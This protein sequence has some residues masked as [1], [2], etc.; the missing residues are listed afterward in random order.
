MDL[1]KIQSEELEIEL[2]PAIGGRINQI[3]S[4]QCASSPRL[5]VEDADSE[6]GGSVPF[7]LRTRQGTEPDTLRWGCYPMA[8]WPGRIASG[9][10][11]FEG[12]PISLPN[13]LG[14]SAIHG[15]A[16]A[17]PWRVIDRTDTRVDLEFLLDEP[18]PW[19]GALRQSVE[20]LGNT[21]DL[22]LEVHAER[23]QRF[24][25]GAGWHPWFSRRGVDPRVRVNA[26]EYLET[27][28]ALIPTGNLLRA[29][30]ESDLTGGAPLGARRLDQVYADPV[31]PV[32]IDW[33]DLRLELSASTNATCVCIY[34]PPEGFCVEP[35]TC[36]ADAFNAKSGA[37]GF[38][39]SVVDADSPLITHCRLQL[40]PK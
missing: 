28:E 32:T 21:L 37:E 11:S 38:G 12:Q 24:P 29:V 15:T 18:W 31:W 16:F 14:G 40:W 26:S 30:G 9:R 34:T 8:P 22:T 39:P 3:K 23:G 6:C 5:L 36:A 2:I 19:S 27:D 17:K 10:F 13:N 20:L 7:D 33:D 25:A 1:I 35:M 4:L